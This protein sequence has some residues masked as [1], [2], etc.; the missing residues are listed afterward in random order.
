VTVS[1]TQYVCDTAGLRV[2]VAL[3]GRVV[4]LGGR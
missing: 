2:G 1:A 3:K 4:S